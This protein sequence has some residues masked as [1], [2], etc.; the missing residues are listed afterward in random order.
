MSHT[1]LICEAWS[2]HRA[3]AAAARAS[4][5]SDTTSPCPVLL[6]PLLPLSCPALFCPVPSCPRLVAARAAA[7]NLLGP[8]LLVIR[9]SCRVPSDAGVYVIWK[10]PD[11]LVQRNTSSS[12]RIGGIIQS[13]GAG[14]R[15]RELVVAGP[16]VQLL[17][18]QPRW[19]RHDESKLC[20]ESGDLAKQAAGLSVNARQLVVD[21]N[22]E[23]GRPAS[24]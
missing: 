23:W 5:L 19:R 14:G 22:T 24:S 21:L 2:C 8:F 12:G 7:S 17:L 6:C 10:L 3:A 11:R 9:H 20:F 1:A 18:P 4:L 16:L 15:T 13:T